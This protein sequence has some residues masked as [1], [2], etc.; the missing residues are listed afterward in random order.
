[1]VQC[2]SAMRVPLSLPDNRQRNDTGIVTACHVTTAAAYKLK[3]AS[4][5][6]PARTAAPQLHH[7][8]Q[9]ARHT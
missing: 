9:C 1:M 6:T 2:V 8:T 4:S 3:V 7:P 5:A